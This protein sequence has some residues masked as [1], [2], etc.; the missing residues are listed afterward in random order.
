MDVLIPG[1]VL[2]GTNPGNQPNKPKQNVKPYKS[3]A[4]NTPATPKGAVA[5]FAQEKYSERG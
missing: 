5:D 3:N 1:G 4:L 2:I